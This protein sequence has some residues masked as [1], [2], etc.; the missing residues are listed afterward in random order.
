MLKIFL[1]NLRKYNEGQLIGEWVELPCVDEELEAVKE[2]IGISDEPDENGNYYEEW[3]ITDYE[4][5]IQGIT[6]NEDDDLDELNELAEELNDLDDDQIKAMQAFLLD[7]NKFDEALEAAQGGDYT[8]YFGCDTMEDVA[9]QIV[10]ETGLLA[11]VPENVARYFDYEA[12]GRDLDVE[13]SFYNIDGDM[14]EIY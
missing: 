11:N 8:I 4:S 2:R 9:I 10:E 6:V 12:Y 14:V 1:T 5:D 7:G 13:G 3:F